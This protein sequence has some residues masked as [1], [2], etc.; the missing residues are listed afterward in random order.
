MKT[1]PINQRK[2]IIRKST[3]NATKKKR[4]PK[5]F[6]K[7]AVQ[8]EFLSQCISAKL[9][10]DLFNQTSSVVEKIEHLE[11]AIQ[12]LESCLYTRPGHH[13]LRQQYQDCR[14]VLRD[15]EECIENFSSH[16]IRILFSPELF[17]Q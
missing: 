3:A 14:I 15:L 16:Q 10:M 5:K 12:D 13:L 9:N 4:I 6:T 8:K 2:K 11:L 1:P 7:A 17:A